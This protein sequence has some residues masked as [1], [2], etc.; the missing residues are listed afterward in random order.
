MGLWHLLIWII[1]AFLAIAWFS[2]WN[3][4]AF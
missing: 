3:L 2:V 4:P 1:A